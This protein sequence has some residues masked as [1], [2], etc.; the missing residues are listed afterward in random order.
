MRG[1][2]QCFDPCLEAENAVP[3]Q[4]EWTADQPERRADQRETVSDGN[5]VGPRGASRP[6]PGG[7]ADEEERGG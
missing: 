2:Q 4:V 3:Q 5:D 1:T 6:S 7:A